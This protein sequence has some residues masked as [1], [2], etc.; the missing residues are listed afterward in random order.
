MGTLDPGFQQRKQPNFT[1][2]HHSEATMCGFLLGKVR[3]WRDTTGL[4]GVPEVSRNLSKPWRTRAEA[5]LLGGKC[6]GK[7]SRP[8]AAGKPLVE[9]LKAAAWFGGLEGMAKVVN[10]P[11]RDRGR[12]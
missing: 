8:T 3:G 4:A 7:G 1:K 9:R 11:V 6:W 5:S 2:E 12:F 10:R